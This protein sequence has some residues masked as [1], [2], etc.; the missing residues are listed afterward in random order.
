M[1]GAPLAACPSQEGGEWVALVAMIPRGWVA[2]WGC[3]LL[4]NVQQRVELVRRGTAF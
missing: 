2:V 3:D 1:R 4:P